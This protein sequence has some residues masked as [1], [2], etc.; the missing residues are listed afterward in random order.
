LPR[1]IDT[2]LA[3]ATRSDT[4]ELD[5]DKLVALVDAA[6]EA[7]DRDRQWLLDAFD[8][9]PEGISILDKND[10]HVLWNRRYAEMY[11][12]EQLEAGAP[13]EQ[14]LRE[15]L[16]KGLFLDAVGREQEWLAA[17][18]ARHRQPSNT[19]IQHLINDRWVRIEERRTADGG[20]I[21]VR[22]DITELKQREESFRLLFE[23]NPL[24][25][26]VYC[27]KTL[28]FLAVNDA[29]VEHYGYS[30]ER[31]L[32]MTAFDLRAPDDHEDLHRL[33]AAGAPPRHGGVMRRH[34]KSDGTPI[35]VSLY[36]RQLIHEGQTV[37][38]VTA[39]D[40]TARKRAEDEVRETREFLNTIIDNVPVAVTVKEAGGDFRYK[41]VNQAAEK[42][43]G[44]SRDQIV[45][46]SVYDMFPQAVADGITARD[47]ALLQNGIEIILGDRPF[48][49]DTSGIRAINTRRRTV[50]DA[51]GTPRYLLG[52]VEDITELKSAEERIAH[53]ANHDSLTDLPNRA[54]FD[55]HM[56]E[57]FDYA[58]ATEGE[59][60]VI[61]LDLDRFKA[62]NDVFGHTA[63]DVVLQETARRLR[64]ASGD[65]FLARLGG[66]EFTLVVEGGPEV[67]ED[68]AARLQVAMI[69]P[70]ETEGHRFNVGLSIGVA[71]YPLDGVDAKSLLSNA[72]A[73][74]YRAKADGR[75]NV[76]FF[77]AEMDRQLRERR[78][79]QH[80]LRFAVE[81]GELS[82]HYQPQA[83]MNS[84]ITGFEVLARWTHPRLGSVP[85][86]TFIPLAEDSGI[87]IPIGEWILREACRQAVSWARP[88]NV[89]V[90]LSPVQ[91]QHG[92]LPAMVHTILLETGLAAGRLELEITEG[93]LMHDFS[94][95]VAILRR[96][97]ALGVRIA[98]DDFGTGYSSLSYLQS[99]PFDK[100]K[101]DKSF[102]A[103][104]KR[105]PQ[106]AAIIRAVIGLGK[107]LDLPVA[108]EGVETREQFEFLAQE[109]CSEIQGYLIG[110]P[111]PIEAYADII[112][113]QPQRVTIKRA[114]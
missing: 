31:L 95:A 50:V 41:L 12:N 107:G 32:A 7:A 65:A 109:A 64:T 66:D 87:I 71:L 68:L 105:S 1:L 77:E 8:M 33:V 42:F 24:P 5:I 72:D 70:I 61:Y 60:G 48:H 84:V 83:N 114:G 4:G 108:A 52:V 36:S 13:L 54:A 2:Q 98:M 35:D 43:L 30:R 51:G 73:A 100:I 104:L 10:R 21:G 103:S 47:K 40:M 89:A 59:F 49:A 44:M 11:S 26:A 86:T 20:S 14:M 75:G 88:L 78:A 79:M 63:G 15:G 76:R 23:S 97:K 96:L 67:A 39:I 85:P 81:R 29:A 45:G 113:G 62:I 101:I 6:Y 94:Q 111:Q 27:N 19:E 9:I 93:V 34:I 38:L 46:K 99:F 55:K 18:L 106:S 16:H 110:R 92:D 80:E 74:L 112:N 53:L 3:E 102:I 25:M 17:R 22:I 82:L 69:E 56:R 28:Q 57:T 58:A 37:T 90:N 91:F